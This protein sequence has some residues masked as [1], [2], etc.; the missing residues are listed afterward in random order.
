MPYND[1]PEIDRTLA[2]QFLLHIL[3]EEVSPDEYQ[4]VKDT[5]EELRKSWD[6][7]S[8]QLSYGMAARKLPRRKPTDPLKYKASADKILPGWFPYLWTSDCIA[9]VLLLSIPT[10]TQEQDAHD[11]VW[12]VCDAADMWEQ[13]AVFSALPIL[14]FPHIYAK[15]AAEGL[16][17]NM[18]PVFDAV[19]ME[20]PYPLHYF[21]DEAW[22]QMYLKAA[23]S[24]RPIYRISGIPQRANQNLSGIILDYAQER[25]AAGREV[26]PEIWQASGYFLSEEH[27]KNLLKL[28]EHT[29]ETQ[30]AVIALL[31]NQHNIPEF[32]NL[33]LHLTQD[34]TWES[35][36][37]VCNSTSV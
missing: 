20:N 23:F 16:R 5:Y 3:E 25:W 24:E 22:N 27:I 32:Q 30:R 11:F 19:A 26:T 31:R 37:R 12:D 14:P 9:R 6:K 10:F 4:W 36:G 21:S 13:V 29:L 15:I 1:V 33:E 7:M 2:Q 18:A 28:A 17:T 35:L 8:F 34:W